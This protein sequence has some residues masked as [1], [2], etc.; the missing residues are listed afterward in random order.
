MT[1]RIDGDLAV[2]DLVQVRPGSGPHMGREAEVLEFHSMGF[3]A[4]VRFTDLR[5][6]QTILL[7]SRLKCLD[8]I[9]HCAK[10]GISR[11][12]ICAPSVVGTKGIYPL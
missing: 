4:T 10:H 9:G 11:C 1:E 12:T 2:H 5:A 8:P 3:E 6:G 7:T